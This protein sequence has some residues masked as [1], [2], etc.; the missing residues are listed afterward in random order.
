MAK[1]LEILAVTACTDRFDEQ[2]ATPLDKCG[3]I[4]NVPLAAANA[5]AI[6][7]RP[8]GVLLTASTA[9]EPLPRRHI[10]FGWTTTLHRACCNSQ[11]QARWAVFAGAKHLSLRMLE[12]DHHCL[13]F[14][15]WPRED[16]NLLPK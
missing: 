9:V 6:L 7:L 12:R 13:C 2:L 14:P 16:H 3:F 5:L 11:S 15:L 1:S 8:D 4:Q 10:S